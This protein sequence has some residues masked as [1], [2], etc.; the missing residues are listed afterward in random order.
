MNWYHRSA[1]QP[2]LWCGVMMGLMMT[3]G[4]CGN[5]DN[6]KEDDPPLII[7]FPDM[8]EMGP[9]M[10]EDMSEPDMEKDMP[11]VDM[12]PSDDRDNDGILNEMDNCP[13]LANT[14]QQDRDRDGHGDAC[15]TFPYFHDPANPMTFEVLREDQ[16][17]P[18]NDTPQE[19]QSLN[20]GV[21]FMSSGAVGSIGDVDHHAFYI[22]KPTA[23]LVNIDSTSPALYSAAIIAGFQVPNASVFR[24]LAAPAQGQPAVREVF[25]PMAGWYTFAISD[26]RNFINSQQDVGSPQ[27]QYTFR[28]SEIPFPEAEPLSVPSPAMPRDYDGQ[29]K[30]YEINSRT[31]KA[32]QLQSAPAAIGE[33]SLYQ[34]VLNVYDPDEAHTIAFSTA[35]HVNPTT[36]AVNL[37]TLVD[38]KRER[39]WIIEDYVQVNGDP[40]VV[41][42]ANA[43]EIKDEVEDPTAPLDDR[44]AP[45][46]WLDLDTKINGVIDEPR[47]ANNDVADEDLYLFTLNKGQGVKVVVSP[48]IGGNLLPDVDVGHA[49]AQGAES[50]YFA[51]HRT[52][53]STDDPGAPREVYYF[54][55]QEQAGDFAVRVAHDG[56]RRGV[57]V[58]G[59]AF[60]YTVELKPWTPQPD[61]ITSIPGEQAVIFGDGGMGIVAFD[62][63]KD[64]IVNITVVDQN[65]FLD[66]RIY[67]TNTWQELER[68]FSDNLTFLAPE[69]GTYWIEVRDFNGRGT[70]VDPVTISLSKPTIDTFPAVPGTVSG[71][72][73]QPGQED[74]Y[75]FSVKAN[76]PTEVSIAASEF[77][78]SMVF[79]DAATFERVDSASRSTE[80]IMDQDMDL[81]V[82]VTSFGDERGPEYT[83]TLGIA[84]ITA[85][86]VGALPA[87]L[88]GVVD[89]TPFAKWYRMTVQQGTF[90]DLS[91]SED[92][93]DFTS[94]G[95]VFRA[96]DFRFIRSFSATR[97]AR[98][99]PDF[100]GDIYI[101]VYDSDRIGDATYLYDL[102]VSTFTPTPITG[103][104]STQGML[105]SANSSQYFVLRGTTGVV[106]VQVKTDGSWPYRLEVLYEENLSSIGGRLSNGIH[107]YATSEYKNYVISVSNT[108][109]MATGPFDFTITA[110][111]IDGA[112]AMMETEPNE[113]A[114][115]TTIMSLPATFTGALGVPDVEDVYQVD[116][117][118]GQRIWVLAMS[119]NMTG[120][121][122]LNMS[123]SL[124]DPMG[125]VD[126]RDSFSGEGFFPILTDLMVQ[127]TGTYTFRAAIDPMDTDAG[128]YTLFFLAEPVTEVNE[129]EPNNDAATAQDL[130]TLAGN[131][132]VHAQADATDATDVFTFTLDRQSDV[133][134]RIDQAQDGH[135]LRLYD[136]NNMLLNESGA[137][138]DMLAQPVLGPSSL[139]AGTYRI[140]LGGS[141][142]TS[143]AD[144]VI[145]TVPENP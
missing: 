16:A 6:K 75:R 112:G 72:L 74:F 79:Y 5:N 46:W 127:H 9:D 87:T 117:V 122:D 57:P 107:R 126:A 64:E 71:V 137:S 67:D 90:Y 93:M 2:W 4:A 40:K 50:G 7:T 73:S 18:E 45:L 3:L 142:S 62:A 145:L 24:V 101:A 39:Y 77:F 35:E 97:P 134:I 49:Y 17:Y 19:T 82:K 14:E 54:A 123:L 130:G 85:T 21:P 121:Y 76:E 38:R 116:L 128:Q 36:N 1:H 135:D 113:Q 69:A 111:T 114:T 32:L 66:V 56:N 41:F 129:V 109:P 110:Q 118:A 143:K 63:Q 83:Y 37:T 131:V 12:P 136:A 84:P 68:S 70:G 103:G 47:G 31:I 132:V 10:K 65:L 15:D 125:N 43:M 34:P 141:M 33:M 96:S 133:Q 42:Q 30:V 25:L 102:N 51:V 120:L 94:T 53:V 23:L 108:D 52:T 61:K 104:M 80:L 124:I 100:D 140:E 8:E 99:T 11:K 119:A 26:I 22:D 58:G 28:L 91:L 88:S 59:G 98:W 81:I 13:D 144:I 95:R 27:F 29:L 139:A 106:D 20:F 89:T 78:P 115:P 92:V 105:A 48:R 60:G 86:P 44:L 138:S 55:S